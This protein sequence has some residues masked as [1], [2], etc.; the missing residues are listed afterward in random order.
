MSALKRLSSDNEWYTRAKA[1]DLILPYIPE[2]CTKIWEPFLSS[3]VRD[4]QYESVT[5]LREKGFDVVTKREDFF[6]S[7]GAKGAIVVSNPPYYTPKGCRNTKERVIERLCEQ[8][9]PFALLLPTYYLQTKSF[10]RLQDKYGHFSVVIP[11]FKLQYYKV[12][13]GKKVKPEKGCSF[14][15]LWLCHRMSSGPL[16]V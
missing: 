9:R 3:D 12:K 13:N 2:G 16:V 4:E 1:I 7:K 6:A 11:S 15:T 14:Y 5:R 10:K 8:K